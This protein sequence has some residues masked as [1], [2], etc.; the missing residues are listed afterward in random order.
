VAGLCVGVV[1]GRPVKKLLE[2]AGGGGS[3][4]RVGARTALRSLVPCSAPI[5]DLYLLQIRLSIKVE[6]ILSYN[7]HLMPYGFSTNMIHQSF[8]SATR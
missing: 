7:T 3:R 8:T 6:S 4:M 1:G 2:W 5:T